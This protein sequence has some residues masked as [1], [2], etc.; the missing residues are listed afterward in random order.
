MPEP[1]DPAW[2]PTL[3]DEAKF[4]LTLSRGGALLLFTSHKAM[5]EAAQR[6][7]PFIASMGLRAMKQG[8]AP[9]VRLLDA[10]RAADGTEGA[11]LFAT[12][13]FW[14]GVDVRGRALRLVVID[15]LP[16]KVPSDPLQ[17]ARAELCKKRGGNP[18]SDIALP[19]AALTLK[20]GVGRLLRSIDDAGVVAIL[21]GR[22]RNRPYGGR[23]LKALPPMTRVGARRTLVTFWERFVAPPLGLP[24]PPLS[25]EGLPDEAIPVE[26]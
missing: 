11:V 22:L 7:M 18:F 5:E 26:R 14:E 17:L 24:P 15:R 16:F 6:L 8:D 2:R 4:L 23:L 12:H 1:D 19:D 21:D 20:Q 10:L 3:D 25:L 9:K 13:S